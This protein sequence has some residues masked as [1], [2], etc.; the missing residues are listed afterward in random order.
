MSSSRRGRGIGAVVTRSG[1]RVESMR[2]KII[3]EEELEAETQTEQG[4]DLDLEHDSYPSEKEPKT[5]TDAEGP[6]RKRRNHKI[7]IDYF[8]A[9]DDIMADSFRKQEAAYNILE[10]FTLMLDSR[11]VHATFEEERFERAAANI[12]M[13]AMMREMSWLFG[14]GP[15][16]SD[17][18][19]EHTVDRLFAAGNAQK[20]KVSK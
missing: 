16:L 18:I 6:K 5:E 11:G 1:E 19:A 15:D 20:P 12:A 10:A 7:P 4:P 17:R 9:L 8:R 13:V 14:L 2:D 3:G